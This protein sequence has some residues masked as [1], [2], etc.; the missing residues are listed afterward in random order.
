MPDFD[1]DMLAKLKKYDARTINSYMR[2]WDYGTV[3]FEFRSDIVD[4]F[5][6][7]IS[8]NNSNR[9]KLI[10]CQEYKKRENDTIYI[11][12]SQLIYD[13]DV[14]YAIPKEVA[15]LLTR[16]RFG[17]FVK[18]AITLMNN[19]GWE[20]VFSDN[21]VH[22][23][24]IR[25]YC[26]ITV[27]NDNYKPTNKKIFVIN[28]WNE[29][30]VKNYY[31][32]LKREYYVETHR[33]LALFR[34]WL[35]SEICAYFKKELSEKMG[36]KLYLAQW[37]WAQNNYLFPKADITA[38]EKQ[39]RAE[40]S[41]YNISGNE[42]KY[43]DFL[44][45]VYGND[46]SLEYV[47]NVMS[48]PLINYYGAG[49]I[50]HMD[51]SSK[52]LNV[53][54]GERKTLMQPKEYDNSVYML[55]G[56]VFFGYA[57]DDAHTVSSFLQKI[58]N[59]RCQKKTRVVNYGIWGGNIDET[60][61]TLFEIDYKQGDVVIISYAGKIPIGDADISRGLA[62]CN[63]GKEF[64]YEGV[65]H[66]NADGYEKVAQS[67]FEIIEE[68]LSKTITN[69][70]SSRLIRD[71]E[72]IILDNRYTALLEAYFETIK[73]QL[74]PL[75]QDGKVYGCA[76]MNCNPFT[77]GHRYLIEQ[78]AKQADYLIIFVV[79]EDKSYFP[80]KER[81]ELVKKGVSD[82]ANVYVVPSGN[83]MISSI[84][85]PGYFQKDKADKA[86]VDSSKDIEIFG[87][88]IAPFLGI[89]KRFVGSEPTDAVTNHYNETMQKLLPLFG[90]DLVVLE[91]KRTHDK[92]ISASTVRKM[93]QEKNFDAIKEFVP[94]TTLTYLTKKF[95]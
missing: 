91:R 52:F 14:F 15:P 24:L 12:L 18:Q 85:F 16:E 81:L 76:V 51:Y 39:E 75:F 35:I 28:C 41:V 56:C 22:C 48:I 23:D 13:L 36:V 20:F 8:C 31:D 5:L 38:L 1:K 68:D 70:S 27:I 50:R 7:H 63:T 95:K 34:E 30:F 60:Y 29:E 92:L 71:K 6:A 45:Q 43:S 26:D 77:L 53:S 33:V 54:F 11:T 83:L 87:R 58:I 32:A 84:T 3:E 4:A 57:I 62:L 42:E 17:I 88:Y 40:Y 74:P 44:Q 69:P 80:F 10:V 79:E 86:V 67:I 73:T 21:S 90:V 25:A 61:N 94:A 2:F 37:D 78:A 9:K 65:V 64:Y 66:C 47:K 49:S 46:Y 19:R 55:G 59:E 93:I 82:L 72:N 89:T